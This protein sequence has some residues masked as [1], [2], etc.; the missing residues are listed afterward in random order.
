MNAQLDPN[1][2]FS[3]SDEKEPSIW[4]T[5]HDT[6]PPEIAL[7]VW[8]DK[9]REKLRSISSP[10]PEVPEP[11]IVHPEGSLSARLEA[12]RQA[13]VLA[14]N[15]AF[16]KD[17]LSYS[18][19]ASC[20]RIGNLNVTSLNEGAS[21]ECQETVK[22]SEREAIDASAI[23]EPKKRH[24]PFTTKRR[25]GEHLKDPEI[26]QKRKDSK[27]AK[28]LKRN[29][30]KKEQDAKFAELGGIVHPPTVY[31]PTDERK[32]YNKNGVRIT[33]KGRR[34]KR[35]C[36][37]D[38]QELKFWQGERF[39]ECLKRPAAS[40][41]PGRDYSTG[42]FANG[43]MEYL[44]SEA[45]VDTIQFIRNQL[46]PDVTIQ[47]AES[48]YTGNQSDDVGLT[49][50]G[51]LA[52]WTRDQ[53]LN[54]GD[55][56]FQ[57]QI[58]GTNLRRKVYWMLHAEEYSDK[59]SDLRYKSEIYNAKRKAFHRFQK[60]MLN[61]MLRDELNYLAMHF[62]DPKIETVR[63]IAYVSARSA[64]NWNKKRK[65][66]KN[67]QEL[68]DLL[69]TESDRFRD[70]YS[71]VIAQVFPVENKII[72]RAVEIFGATNSPKD[73]PAWTSIDVAEELRRCLWKAKDEVNFSDYNIAVWLDW[74]L[75]FKLRFED[76]KLPPAFQPT[77]VKRTQ[78]RSK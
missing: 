2:T 52:R 78:K 56:K 13:R 36:G 29:E 18:Q 16:A 44:R 60:N 63:P 3:S 72:K 50:S 73:H 20:D 12:A 43:E 77:N 53:D 75:R 57:L 1:K 37:L 9:T 22:K 23:Q 76:L 45:E 7:K 64:S 38:M 8:G 19:S 25:R 10:T 66:L 6:L 48:A 28:K 54:I 21:P 58:K 33:A 34:A 14:A 65:T 39:D 27:R 15:E 61:W 26:E 4:Q 11:V 62:V 35:Q 30:I 47:N 5:C 42:H 70:Y 46:L 24:V 40:L 74:R 71:E 32:K 31:K 17:A 41:L 67:S 68:I 51:N 69:N 59:Y 49:F 55:D